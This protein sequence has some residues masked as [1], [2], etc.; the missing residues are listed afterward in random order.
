[1]YVCIHNVFTYPKLMY[2]RIRNTVESL[3]GRIAGIS[4]SV[5]DFLNKYGTKNIT[6]FMTLRTVPLLTNAIGV[7]SQSFRRKSGDTKLYHLHTLI[8]TTKTNQS[9]EK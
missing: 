4:P 9:L 3:Q 7:I 5:D 8:R 6:Q 1:M 2:S